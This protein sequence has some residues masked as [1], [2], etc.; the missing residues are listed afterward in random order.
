MENYYCSGFQV[1]DNVAS[2]GITVKGVVVVPA[3]YIP[4]Y[5]LV[6]FTQ[7]SGLAGTNA[8]VWG[9]EEIGADH[10][11]GNVNVTYVITCVHSPPFDVAV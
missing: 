8:G 7:N 6:A 9:T 1:G 10:I 4:H 3:D 11:S 5:Y 2:T